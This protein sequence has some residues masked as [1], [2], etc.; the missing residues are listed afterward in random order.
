[1][2][3]WHKYSQHMN[4]TLYFQML[5]KTFPVDYNSI[6]LQV[7]HK[8]FKFMI[9]KFFRTYFHSEIIFLFVFLFTLKICEKCHLPQIFFQAFIKFQIH[10]HINGIHQTFNLKLLRNNNPNENIQDTCHLL[11]MVMWNEILQA[12]TIS[13][14]HKIPLIKNV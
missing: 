5:Q 2:Q 13:S 3:L 4:S 10:F 9:V 14:R 1:M 6:E 7:P 8:L 12:R 11:K